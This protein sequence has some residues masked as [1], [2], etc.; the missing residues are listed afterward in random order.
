MRLWDNT[1]KLSIFF[2]SLGFFYECGGK[3]LKDL[4]GLDLS[5]GEAMEFLPPGLGEDHFL[6]F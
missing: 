1:P 3:G 4:L 2:W 6:R 5:G